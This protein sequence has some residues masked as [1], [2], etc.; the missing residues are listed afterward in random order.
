MG[1]FVYMHGKPMVP[2]ERRGE[3]AER[4][5]RL[6]NQG[7]MMTVNESNLLGHTVFLLSPVRYEKERIWFDYNYFEDD[8]WEAAAYDARDACLSSNK[9]S[10]GQFCAVLIAAYL[11][12]EFY[13]DSFVITQRDGEHVNGPAY[14]GWL[15]YLFGES[16]TNSRA[17][18][19]WEIYKVIRPDFED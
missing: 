3:L 6:F 1:S 10:S 2:E 12:L 18:N 8:F 17:G 11:L 15:N 4:M 9:V 5:E 14:I 16:Y 19:L 13:S 7:G